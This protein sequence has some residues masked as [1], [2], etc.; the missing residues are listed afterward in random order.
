MSDNQNVYWMLELKIKDGQRAPFEQLMHAMV[1]STQT[2]PGALDYRWTIAED[3][4]S[5]HILERYTDSAATLTHL[6][7][8][9]PPVRR[10]VH[11]AH[12]ARAPHGVRHA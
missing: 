11:G 4:Q 6:A 7:G 2:E 1:E 8:F 10:Q 5:C 12:R 9:G 3:G